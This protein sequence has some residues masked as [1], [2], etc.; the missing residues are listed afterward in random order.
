[1]KNLFRNLGINILGAANIYPASL[2]RKR[3]LLALME[4]LHPRLPAKP[5]VRLGPP[6]DG[7]YLVPDDLA[8]IT[9]CYSPGVSFESGFE[10]ACA[11][12]GM[13]VYMADKSVDGPAQA[14]ANF[15]FL[16][17]Y[18]GAATSGDF[19]SMDDW[20]RSTQPDAQSDLALQIDIEG[21]EYETFFSMS[22]TLTRRFRVIAGELHSMDMLWSKH[23]FRVVSRVFDK[24][25]QTHT[26]VHLHPNNASPSVSMKGLEIPRLMEFTFVRN[27][28]VPA[29]AGY[30]RTF[31]HAL[32]ADNTSRA[33]L[34]L[35]RCWHRQ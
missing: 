30:A 31:P 7:G 32:D 18:I 14:H 28:R 27:D 9:A 5:L 2:T 22:D 26:C 1:M 10:N 19:I 6:G 29:D 23:Y 21:Y 16:K 12:R 15:H 35:P 25:L 3:D 20:V 13:Q 8:G 4:K 34:P 17:K 11:E 33:P 24:L